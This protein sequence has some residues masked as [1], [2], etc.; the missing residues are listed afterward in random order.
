MKEAIKYLLFTILII[1]GLFLIWYFRSIFFF[2]AISAV[3]SLIA[4]PLSD[5]F[6]RI[7]IGRIQVNNTMAALFTVLIIW[8]VIVLFFRFTIPLIGYE[9]Q[10]MSSVD[11][12]QV[13]E[14]ISSLLEDILS[15]FKRINEPVVLVI[16]EQVREAAIALFDISQIKDAFSGLVGF[17]GGLFVAVLSI[18]FITF[19]FLKDEGLLVGLIM[20]IIPDEYEASLR[21]VLLSVKLLLR[22]Y[23]TGVLIQ[24]FLITFF[25]T[26]GFLI[27]GVG[28][29]HAVTIG[30]ISGLLNIIPYVGPLIGAFFGTIT[31]IIVFLQ[32]PLT[33]DFISFTLWIIV[34]YALVQIMDNLLFQPII[35]SNS[36]KAHPLEI[37]IV[38]LM[39]GYA[40]GLTGMF[41][42]IPVYTILRVIAREFFYNYRVVKKLTDGL[43]GGK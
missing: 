38:I 33:G 7:H 25:V 31:G 9:I 37:F 39:A 34:I 15:P 22:R 1:G 40:S 12:P 28:F 20:L 3:L 5:V 4:R 29:N 19:F 32:T 27:L 8:T 17:V 10:Y 11:I 35:F 13:F 42:A 21:H 43:R 30:L 14:R 41:L 16:E 26:C 24:I 36:V 2:I 18:T 23:F 6:K